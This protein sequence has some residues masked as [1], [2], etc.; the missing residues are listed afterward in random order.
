MKIRISS[1]VLL[2]LVL[3]AAT[4]TEAQVTNLISL[5]F[6]A[7]G[8]SAITDNGTN[9]SAP[10]PFTKSVT[11]ANVLKALAIAE[12]TLGNYPT[13]TFPAGTRLAVITGKHTRFLVLDSQNAPILDADDFIFF[14][15]GI[16]GVNV[17]SGSRNDTTGLG[18]K[19]YTHLETGSFVY[20][21][22]WLLGTNGVK[23]VLNGT[24]NNTVTD[25]FAANGT[26]YTETQSHAIKTAVGEG[27][28]QGTPF[29]LSGSFSAGGSGAFTLAP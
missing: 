7:K 29:V 2:A 20:W 26:N 3:T 27:V 1:R 24:M 23:F 19:T 5:S 28:W 11:T 18:N 14:D 16:F 8:Q 15:G 12:N 13:N 17:F 25:K 9:T 6:T 4:I 21:D 22:T 10:A